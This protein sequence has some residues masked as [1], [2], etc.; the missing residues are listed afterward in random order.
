MKNVNDKDLVQELQDSTKLVIIDFWA[1]WCGPC[2]AL[3]PTLEKVS[4]DQA[5]SV[6]V[7]K[8]NVDENPDS[9]RKYKIRGI[10]T[11]VFVKN[12]EVVETLVGNQPKEVIESKIKAHKI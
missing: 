5:D 10:P 7:L 4:I 9:A 1:E 2:K 12:G 11:M 3:S 6:N 8:L